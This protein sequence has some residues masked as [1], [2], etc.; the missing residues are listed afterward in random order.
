MKK[1]WIAFLLLASVSAQ[2]QHTGYDKA[3][4]DSLGADEYGMKMYVL[5]LLK[6][7]P[8]TAV[9]KAAT[10]SLFT[11][12]MANIGRL[13]AQGKLVLAGPMRKNERGL[14]GLFLF[15]VPS[16]AEAHE[17]LKTDP[18]VAAGLLDAELYE[19][20]GSAAL[21]TYLPNHERVQKKRH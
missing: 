11:G 18:A 17:L 16:I 8:A 3:L 9:P 4:A 7:G 14:R 6:T 20:Y 15:N 2:A 1:I 21:P 19:W 13:A 5:V 12:H 10:D